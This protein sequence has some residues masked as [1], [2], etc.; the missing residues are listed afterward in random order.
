MT[1]REGKQVVSPEIQSRLDLL[2]HLT[3]HI[4]CFES[5]HGYKRHDLIERIHQ[6]VYNKKAYPSV[7]NWIDLLVLQ[8][9]I[10]LQRI[11]ET[12]AQSIVPDTVF[13]GIIAEIIE[14]YNAEEIESIIF[15]LN[16]KHH[17]LNSLP[18]NRSLIEP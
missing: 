16:N 10:D 14:S 12:Q 7:N 2:N 15:Q 17:F 11:D 6:I 5:K 1:V 13:S 8:I 18:I 9:A 3:K 4:D